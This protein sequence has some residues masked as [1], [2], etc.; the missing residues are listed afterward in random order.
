MHCEARGTKKALILL[1]GGWVGEKGEREIDTKYA[2]DSA[3]TCSPGA[4]S[5]GAPQRQRC[6]RRLCSW[7][8]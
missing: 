3:A 7:A 8:A 1:S 5:P 6:P 2:R 4:R